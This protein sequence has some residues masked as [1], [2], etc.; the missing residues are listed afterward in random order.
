LAF[1]FDRYLAQL[2]SFVPPPAMAP[3]S[4]PQPAGCG[5]IPV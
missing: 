1:D 2:I 4:I 5:E 3:G